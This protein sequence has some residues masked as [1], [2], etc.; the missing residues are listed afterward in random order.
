MYRKPA[1]PKRTAAVAPNGTV[2]VSYDTGWETL[3]DC[4]L[5]FASA[6]AAKAH[7][8]AD[9]WEE[10][11]PNAALKAQGFVWNGYCYAMP[12]PTPSAA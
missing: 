7:L 10:Y 4:R 5:T 1:D 12:S 6:E 11:D 2:T 8:I 3:V 9:G